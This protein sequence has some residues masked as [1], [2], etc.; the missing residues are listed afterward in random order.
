MTTSFP[1]S[2]S[3]RLCPKTELINLLLWGVY[4]VVQCYPCVKFY[5]RLFL[6]MVMYDNDFE[7]KENKI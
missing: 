6:G 5:F 7:T 1:S 3:R 2:P 4:V